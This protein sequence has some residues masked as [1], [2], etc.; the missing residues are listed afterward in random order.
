M[1][2]MVTAGQLGCLLMGLTLLSSCARDE[3]IGDRYRAERMYYRAS[4]LNQALQIN[5][6]ELS[7]EQY[8]QARE[9][10]HRIVEEYSV[11]ALR[12]A[13]NYDAGAREK[14]FTITGMSQIN[15]ADLFL[16]EGRI[17]SAIATYQRVMANYGDYP[18]LTSRALYSLAL[19]YQG[20]D[21]WPEAVAAFE[22]LL[23]EYPP[24][25]ETPQQPDE[26]ILKLPGY[27]ASTFLSHGD[28]AKAGEYFQKARDY[29]SQ[30]IEKWPG[31]PTARLALNQIVNTHILQRQWAPAVSALER[32]AAMSGEETDPPDALFLMATLCSERL[33]D[34]QRAMDIYEDMLQR[35]PD[36]K[37]LSRTYLAMGQLFFQKGDLSEARQAFG[38]V[39]EDYPDDPV[40]G[41]AAQYAL[42]LSYEF[43]GDW[44]KAL[45]EFRWVLDNYPGSR[46]AFAVPNH[47]LEHYR[48][49]EEKELALTAYRQALRTYG[50]I[51]AKHPGS[52]QALQGQWHI[53]QAHILMQSWEEAAAALEQLVQDYPQS[54][55]LLP[56]L[57]SLGE[58]YELHLR[59]IDRAIG[60]YRM[61]LKFAPTSPYANVA[62]EHIERLQ[63][64][65]P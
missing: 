48:Q 40:A 50:D 23:K 27:L 41:A 47:I 26:N 55:Q 53:A 60:A 56:A 35:Y 61:V 14:L 49:Y 10:F 28:S 63:K 34:L 64:A 7:P 3:G 44:D 65:L 32:L 33:G 16:Q 15:M 43:E 45:N 57:M 9:S 22:T 29:L 13:E 1:S 38:R 24:F 37:K 12:Q 4:K 30:V 5:R 18:A 8:R 6:E 19:A 59:K 36:S 46:E 17:D 51:V 11:A 42:A 52:P 54:Q 2:R 39:I 31:T 58:I 21:R 20:A 62:A 25:R